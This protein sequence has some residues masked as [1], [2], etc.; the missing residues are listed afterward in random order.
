MSSSFNPRTDTIIVAGP[1]ASGKS[2]LAIDIAKACDGVIINGDSMQ[3]Y[4][5]L[6]VVTACP[7]D[8]EQSQVP[9]RLYNVLDGAEACSVGKWLHLVRE[10]V[11]RVRALGCVP[12]LCG[13]TALYLNAA[14]H[15]MSAIPDIPEDV[16]QAVIKEHAQKGGVQLLAELQAIDPELAARL[17]AGD[18]QRITRAIEVFRHTNRKLSDWQN[19]PQQGHLSGRCFNFTI[20]PERE[21]LYQRINQRFKAMWDNG[22]VPEVAT[23]LARN[24]PPKLPVMKA[25]G[26]P[27]IAS[28]LNGEMTKEE[29]I[30]AASQESRRYAKR[31]FTFFRNNFIT[32]YLFEETYLKSKNSEFFANILK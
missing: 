20:L 8:D 29:A 25:V 1:T 6:S 2:A 22:A 3:I 27:Q 17:A 21:Q 31:Q 4:R 13:G 23:L 16:H 14:Q 26:V 19:D 12:I 32:N 28:F 10:E 5:D 7:D 9:H 15:G 30:L 18:S 11:A 24:L